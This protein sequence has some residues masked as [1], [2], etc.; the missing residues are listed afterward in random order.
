MVGG[1]C[2][3]YQLRQLEADV[4]WGAFQPIGQGASVVGQRWWP[5]NGDRTDPD[6]SGW[7]FGG[8]EPALAGYE[9]MMG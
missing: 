6:G 7:F 3:V 9:N 1:H 2:W 8:Y 4:T 5:M